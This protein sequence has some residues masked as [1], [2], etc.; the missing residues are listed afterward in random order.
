[1][2]FFANKREKSE[3]ELIEGCIKNDRFCQELFYRQHFNMALSVVRRYTSDEHR[4][5]EIL[6]NGFLRAFQKIA[7]FQHKGSMEGWLRKIIFH[8]VSDYFRS[9]SNQVKFLELEGKTNAVTE[10]DAIDYL[11]AEE[12]DEL[13]HELPEISKRV[14]LLFVFD[15]YGHK[16]IAARLDI[17]EGTS[18][19]HLSNARKILKEKYY[20]LHRNEEYRSQES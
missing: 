10:N 20:R 8:A 17:A 1:V 2:R 3:K 16:E 9:K 6:N 12:I 15:G 4:Q 19:W 14:L 5:L 7:Q 18:K 11:F 13:I